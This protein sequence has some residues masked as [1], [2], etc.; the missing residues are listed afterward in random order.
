[1]AAGVALAGLVAVALYRSG[2]TP[3]TEAVEDPGTG[4]TGVASAEAESSNPFRQ[5]RGRWARS[6]GDYLL[7]VRQAGPDGR[8]QVD[9]LNPRPVHVS[10]AEAVAQEGKVKLLVELQDVGYPGCVYTLVYDAATDRM[11]GSYYQAAMRETFAVEFERSPAI[12]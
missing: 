10:R 12:R 3:E 2:N 11:T 9:Y 4:I 8:V 5:L 7:D 1:V 6:D